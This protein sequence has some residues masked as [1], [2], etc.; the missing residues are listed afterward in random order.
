MSKA[1]QKVKSEPKLKRLRHIK[2]PSNDET[3]LIHH[4]SSPLSFDDKKTTETTKTTTTTTTTSLDTYQQVQKEI[5]KIWSRPLWEQPT[6]RDLPRLARG[7][8]IYR[9]LA[10][11]LVRS[12]SFPSLPFPSLP[13]SPLFSFFHLFFPSSICLSLSSSFLFISTDRYLK[14]KKRSTFMN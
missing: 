6:N 10:N 5:E 7:L 12:S 13:F 11:E 4:P 1:L 2:R 3:V 8:K 9:A 14:E